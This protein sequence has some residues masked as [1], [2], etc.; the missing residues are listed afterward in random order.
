M[1][2]IEHFG[3]RAFDKKY[4]LKL[5]REKYA[6]INNK[7]SLPYFKGM[8]ENY[9]DEAGKFYKDKWC[10]KYQKLCLENFDLNMLFFQSLDYAKFN[11]EVNAMIDKYKLEEVEDLKQYDYFGGYYLMVL[12]EYNQVYVGYS[13]NI[14]KRIQ[15]HWSFNKSLDRLLFPMY[16]IKSSRLSIDSFRALDT[17]RLYA[18]KRRY[19]KKFE[20]TLIKSFSDDFVINRVSGGLPKYIFELKI[21]S[22][23][24]I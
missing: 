13:S 5:T 23:K 10:A 24:L 18:I 9:A 20:D 12:D 22:R 4:G 7:S 8:K 6:L 16:N 2:Y 15:Q 17:T 3:V 19:S 11:N 21:K 14:R 1:N